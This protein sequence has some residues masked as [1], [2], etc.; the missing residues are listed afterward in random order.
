MIEAVEQ[1]PKEIINFGHSCGGFMLLVDMVLGS[2]NSVDPI[3]LRTNTNFLITNNR[4]NHQWIVVDPFLANKVFCANAFSKI[5]WSIVSTALIATF[6]FSSSLCIISK[7][8]NKFG[9][10]MHPF[11][12]YCIQILRSIGNSFA[13]VT[14][15]YKRFIF[16]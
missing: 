10:F 8:E 13:F 6:N 4:Q 9:V 12:K 2:E 16:I 11:V 15:T 14:N 7:N 3:N 5:V 1:P